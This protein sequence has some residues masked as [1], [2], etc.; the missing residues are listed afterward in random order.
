MRRATTMLL[1]DHGV[2][3]GLEI[4]SGVLST[5]DL[6]A[7]LCAVASCEHAPTRTRFLLGMVEGL[8]LKDQPVALS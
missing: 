7:V 6:A 3:L 8:A 1:P 5:S 2:A 4:A